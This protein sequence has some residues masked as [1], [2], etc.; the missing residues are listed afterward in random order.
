MVVPVG[1]RFRDL[2]YAGNSSGEF[3]HCISLALN[4]RDPEGRRQARVAMAR[5]H[6]WESLVARACH[7]IEKL[8]ERGRLLSDAS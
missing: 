8:G 1:E 2:C 5:A 6:S 7:I 3:L 4:E